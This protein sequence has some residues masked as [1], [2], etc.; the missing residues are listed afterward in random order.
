MT[1]VSKN[2]VPALYC[3][4]SWEF[5]CELP[6]SLE[7]DLSEFFKALVEVGFLHNRFVY[8]PISSLL[9]SIL[10]HKS[11]IIFWSLLDQVGIL[12]IEESQLDVV[13]AQGPL[14]WAVLTHARFLGYWPSTKALTHVHCW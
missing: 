5:V 1:S 10:G 4:C 3:S 8:V 12:D 6:S 9:F 13:N 2:S 14:H 7:L 11:Q